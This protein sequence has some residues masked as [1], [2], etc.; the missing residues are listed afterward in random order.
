MI[1]DNLRITLAKSKLQ[2]PTSNIE[3]EIRLLHTLTEHQ[4][5]IFAVAISPDG[6]A[7]ASAGD[8]RS[9]KLWTIDGKLLHSIIAHEGRIFK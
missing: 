4:A 6:K 1:L 7:I 3:P 8:D 9:I 2:T 5:G